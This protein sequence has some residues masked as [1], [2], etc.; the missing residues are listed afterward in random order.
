MKFTVAVNRDN[1]KR[2]LIH[3][4]F[5]GAAG[6]LTAI[7]AEVAKLDVLQGT[8]AVGFVSTAANALASFIREA[9]PTD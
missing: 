2:A 8:A 3:L 6:A 7:G 9:D 4:A 1:V 5:V